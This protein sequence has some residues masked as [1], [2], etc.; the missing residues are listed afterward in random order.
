MKCSGSVK[1]SCQEAND[2]SLKC[3]QITQRWGALHEGVTPIN[4]DDQLLAD[5]DA[6]LSMS[7]RLLYLADKF[8]SEC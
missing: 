3:R 5:S 2:V 8:I 6:V 7:E 4:R 1:Y